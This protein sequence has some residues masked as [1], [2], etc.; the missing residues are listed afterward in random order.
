MKA[1]HCYIIEN[2]KYEFTGIY[3]TN[4][5]SERLFIML[6]LSTHIF[7]KLLAYQMC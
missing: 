6:F 1:L 2:T 5:K 4:L 7:V 3:A